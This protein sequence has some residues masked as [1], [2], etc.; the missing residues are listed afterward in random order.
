[1]FSCRSHCEVPTVF[2]Y[3]AYLRNVCAALHWQH[4][5]G[6]VNDWLPFKMQNDTKQKQTNV[7]SVSVS[8]H[9]MLIYVKNKGND[10]IFFQKDLEGIEYMR[11]FANVIKRVTPQE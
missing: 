10:S 5:A 7:K 6:W 8:V 9:S 11:T 4:E 2:L 3:I 1:M